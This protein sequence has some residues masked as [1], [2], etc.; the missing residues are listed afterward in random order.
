MMVVIM[1]MAMMM[2]PLVTT[3]PMM[4]AVISRSSC[5]KN[6]HDYWNNHPVDRYNNSEQ[7]SWT[8][9]DGNTSAAN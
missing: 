9:S 2:F 3:M 5:I 1:T 7:W 6:A 4:T 8:S